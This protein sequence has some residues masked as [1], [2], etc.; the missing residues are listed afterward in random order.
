M[1]QSVTSVQFLLE[2]FLPSLVPSLQNAPNKILSLLVPLEM[3][4]VY[5]RLR[6]LFFSPNRMFFS[7]TLVNN[8]NM[9]QTLSPDQ[10]NKF[11]LKELDLDE[12]EKNK[13]EMKVCIDEIKGNLKLLT[14]V[15]KFF[16]F[17][18]S[19]FDFKEN[20]FARKERLRRSKK[21][22]ASSFPFKIKAAFK[23]DSGLEVCTKE[24]RKARFLSLLAETIF[25][26]RPVLYCFFLKFL[27]ANSWKP[28][29]I[30]FVIDLIWIVLHFIENQ[31]QKVYEKNIV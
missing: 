7:E 19:Q 2:N 24:F 13:C 1:D 5:I 6:I 18:R 10:M 4:K 31:T 17:A 15:Q 21:V 26:I 14:Q 29:L 12:V 23:P 25:I 22:I 11:E 3:L 8:L 20:P 9:G 27:G 28:F 16:S 30:N